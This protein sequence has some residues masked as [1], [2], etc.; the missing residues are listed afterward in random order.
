MKR[1][2]F[3]GSGAALTVAFAVGCA[4][5]VLP[6]RP[7][8][9]ADDAQ[10]WIRHQNGKY[11]LFLPRAEMGQNI[12][13]ALKQIAC[14]E[15][16]IGW[17]DLQVS[18]PA[19]T[20]I[21]P[22]RATVG[23]ESIKDFA[24]PLAQACA[25][26]R[27]ALVAGQGDGH[28]VA[29]DIPA[30]EL[31]SFAGGGTGTKKWIGQ[32]PLVAQADA[33]VRGA[34]VYAGDI[35]LPGMVF[36]RVLRAP[37]SPELA[38][39]PVAWSEQAAR[40]VKGFIGTVQDPLFE[41]GRSMGLGILAATPGALDRISVALAVQWD[42][43]GSFD[44]GSVD[45]AIDI[46]RRL[47]KGALSHSVH[48]DALAPVARWDV[49]LRIDL[50]A[51]A[52]LSIEPRV[53]VAQFVQADQLRMWVGS[54]DAFFVRDVL[55]KQLGL[56]KPDVSVQAM[57]VG[58]AFGG[59]TICTVELEAAVLARAASAP[60]KVQWT[61]AQEL[62]F[63]FHRPPSSH[64]L[65][66][67]LRDQ[68]I[69]QWSHAF[70]SGHIIFTN[71]GFPPWLQ[72]LADFVGDMGVARGADSPYRAQRRRVQFDQ[73]RL[74]ILTGPWRGL[75]AGP[76]HLAIES[77]IDECARVLNEDPV[78]FRLRHLDDKRLI[79]VLQRV[80]KVG[81]WGQSNTDAT[82]DVRYGRGI[83]CGIYKASSYAAVVAEVRVHAD[84]E[85]QV[86]SLTCAHDCGQVIN[87]D[88]VKAQCEG[89]LVWGMGMVMTDHLPIDT[90][91][92]AAVNFD[93]ARLP[94]LPDV[95]DMHIHLI[96]NDSPP[97]GAGETAIVAAS[98]AIANA[99]RDATGVRIRRFPVAATDLVRDLANG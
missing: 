54:Q 85:V 72:N 39:R 28:R 92:I 36:G 70:A 90:A 75:G 57:R 15:L 41:Q 26:L 64:R 65:R 43:E 94:R 29:R 33:I 12:S 8:A 58:G 61:R 80:A 11:R 52:H 37:A 59:K 55:S 87:P 5:P 48:K 3:L 93:R 84:G 9:S 50:P 51:A 78:Q 81:S 91:H 35:R 82:P 98:G 22:V 44:Q 24:L 30:T 38:S 83:A 74:P 97:S 66:I 17:D 95:P 16:G 27:E 46:D 45:E 96:D 60:V 14:E 23:S 10:A 1:R 67:S 42:I 6:K 20:D 56:A 19:T 68:K 25:T 31:R 76:N 69:D 47:A 49:D 99:I 73:V 71:A 62:Q 88:Q 53:A 79:R 4:I 7:E 21:G 32:T 63:G 89:N 18:L 34:P 77:A 13:T 2:V 86:I 40:Q